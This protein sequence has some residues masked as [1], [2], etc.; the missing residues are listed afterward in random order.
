M[1]VYVET[2]L[3]VVIGAQESYSRKRKILRKSFGLISASYTRF[4][5]IM[6]LN[7]MRLLYNSSTQ[8]WDGSQESFSKR[9]QKIKIKGC[10][11]FLLAVCMVSDDIYSLKSIFNLG[12]LKFGLAYDLKQIAVPLLSV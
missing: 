8:T 3:L 4:G 1:L 10:A 9:T 7:T 11:R 2:D 6:E 5:E 12:V